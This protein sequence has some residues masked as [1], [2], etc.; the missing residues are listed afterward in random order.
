M[1]NGL[2]K[3]APVRIFVMGANT[4]RDEQEWPLARA[5]DTRFYLHSQG[6]A[7][8]RAG[9]GTLSQEAPGE[10]PVDRYQYD[11]RHPVPT[12][13][14]HGCCGAGLTP[15]GPLDQRATQQRHDLLVYTTAPLTGDTEVTGRPELQLFFSTDVTDTDLFVTLSDV[16]P[17]GKAILITEGA[18]RTRFRESLEKPSLLKPNEVYD[19]KIP[20]WETS[21]L[22][23]QGHRIR[24]HVTSSN[25]PRFNR[26]L[27]SG[28]PLGEETE[29]DIRVATQTIYHDSRRASSIVLPVVPK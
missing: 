2:D 11:P 3:E 4:W 25:F 7:N 23:K 9:D 8:T 16:Y 24:V 14:G 20:L 1:Q 5:R 17:D 18:L 6:F 26:N 29:A 12:W 10:Q 28:K 15:E 19:V 21:N 22:F 27:N 13:G